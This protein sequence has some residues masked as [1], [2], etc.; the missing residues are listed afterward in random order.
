MKARPSFV[1]PV[2]FFVIPEGNLRLFPPKYFLRSLQQ[3]N[4]CLGRFLG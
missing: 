4:L 2:L 1:I 3:E